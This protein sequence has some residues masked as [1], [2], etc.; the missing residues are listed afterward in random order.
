MGEK[1]KKLFLWS[2]TIFWMVLIFR[3]SAQ[4]ASVSGNLSGGMLQSILALFTPDWNSLSPHAQ[5]EKL[6]A[7][8]TIFRK[9]AHFSIYAVLG[10]LWTST[11]RFGHWRS[12]DCPKW[13]ILLPILLCLL[14]AVSDEIHQMFSDGRSCE[15]R[16]IC[17]DF[18]GAATGI[19]CITLLHR[20][21]LR[22]QRSY[23][24]RKT[25]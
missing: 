25:T 14:Y 3:L 24:N 17:I 11:L 4:S 6:D 13:R 12:E 18:V 2:A 7:F 16:D 1:L 15:L 23:R 21:V 20:I 19:A 9:F 22:I 8:H 10:I 5:A